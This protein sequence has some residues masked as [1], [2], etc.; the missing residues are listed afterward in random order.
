MITLF[1]LFSQGLLA[2]LLAVGPVPF[3]LDLALYVLEHV[4][5]TDLLV[6]SL[7]DGGQR[8]L[9]GFLEVGNSD[10]R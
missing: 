10:C 3:P 6:D 9:E 1:F 8:I 5:Q 2:G 7:L 4:P